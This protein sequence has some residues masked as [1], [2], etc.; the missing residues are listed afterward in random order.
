MTRSFR[1]GD[2]V[3]WNSEAGRVAG[4]IIKVHQKDIRYK[5]YTHHATPEDP[6]YEIK[7]DKSYHIALHKS[8]AL[9]LVR[10]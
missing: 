7:S 4:T 8:S 6:Q 2:H 1:I 3:T 5:E 10:R 9:R